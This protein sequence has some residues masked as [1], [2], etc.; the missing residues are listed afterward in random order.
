MDA[1][2]R[3]RLID[4]R[5]AR[6]SSGRRPVVP[7]RL[8]MRLN[9]RQSGVGGVVGLQLLADRERQDHGRLRAAPDGR[10]GALREG[11]LGWSTS[12]SSGRS[13][14][15]ESEV[16]MKRSASAVWRGVSR[17]EGH[18]L[19][20]ERC[21]R[22]ALLLHERSRRDGKKPGRAHRGRARRLLLDGDRVQLGPPRSRRDP[23][24]RGDA[25]DGEARGRVDDHGHPPRRACDV[26]ALRGRR[27][28]R[29]ATA[30]NGCPVSRVL[31][32]RYD[33]RPARRIS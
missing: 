4:L 19:D 5:D 18:G 22:A 28:S 7:R 3:G 25:H 1:A 13:S 17:T 23:S 11:A 32:P 14:T 12:S 33:E 8:R 15:S 31:T 2:F 27:S 30:K 21:S 9:P 16:S 20:G 6:T 29:G 26:P 10:T 24:R